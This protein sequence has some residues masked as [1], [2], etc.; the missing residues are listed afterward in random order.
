MKSPVR[1]SCAASAQIFVRGGDSLGKII[2]RA[3]ILTFA[4]AGMYLLFLNAFDNILL[5]CALAFA[6]CAILIRLNARRTWN[7]RMSALQAQALLNQW[8]YG[9]DGDAKRAIAK[10]LSKDEADLVYLPRL[11]AATLS[12]GD[13]FSTWK[14]HRGREALILSAPCRAD[15]RARAL[16]RSLQDPVVELA[17][18]AR[19]IPLIRRSN[20]T[21]PRV[22]RAKEGFQRL[23]AILLAL[24]NRRPWHQTLLFGL[25]LMGLYWLAGNPAYLFLSIGCL[26]LAGIAHHVRD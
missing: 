7:A 13:V 21:P 14:A 24:P 15:S 22:R 19:L 3:V 10:L 8:A 4:A 17:D 6:C 23:K 18:A 25:A 20:L 9:D 12:A 5:A 26:F 11:P 16:A 2:D 1:I